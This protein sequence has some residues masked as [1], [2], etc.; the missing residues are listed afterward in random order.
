MIETEFVTELEAEAQAEIEPGYIARL[1]EVATTE[2]ALRLN[3]QT[4]AFDLS[5]EHGNQPKL[6]YA[7]I[8]A[9]G[10]CEA[11]YIEFGTLETGVVEKAIL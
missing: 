3:R 7:T 8:D 6:V 10:R 9:P 4:P 11:R 5:R 1:S 2:L